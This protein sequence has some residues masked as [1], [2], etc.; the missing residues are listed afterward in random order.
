MTFG[1][2]DNRIW[3]L[4][5]NHISYVS[6]LSVCI[7]FSVF[8][9]NINLNTEKGWNANTG[10]SGCPILS[11]HLS[12]SERT[13]QC[14]A[15]RMQSPT[16]T[17]AVYVGMNACVCVPRRNAIINCPRTDSRIHCMAIFERGRLFI[18]F[19]PRQLIQTA[20]VSIARI[21]VAILCMYRKTVQECH[22]T[23]R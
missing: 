1:R 18:A 5:N 22:R 3:P 15:A 8:L 21:H 4:N 12:R 2:T 9:F 19:A 7:S 11:V 14:T 23:E 16:N 17:H 10:G 13:S 6:F 20:F